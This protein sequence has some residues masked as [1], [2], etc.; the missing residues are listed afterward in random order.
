MRRKLRLFIREW[1]KSIG[2]SA[3]QCADALGFARESYLRMEREP[4]RINLE[5]LEVIADT[6]GVKS[7]RLHFPP[8]EEGQ[9]E[10]VSLDELLEDVPENVRQ[11]AIAAVRGMIGK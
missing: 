11:L 6:I 2:V 8:P 5:E 10:Q 7:G 9:Q 4:R 1:R 3:A